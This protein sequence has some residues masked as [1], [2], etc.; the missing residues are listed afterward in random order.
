MK[1]IGI[2][3][4]ELSAVISGMGHRDMLGVVDAGFPITEKTQRIDLALDKGIPGFVETIKV[5]AKELEVEKIYLAK[6][7]QDI[8]PNIEKEI[9]NTFKDTPIEIVDHM[10]L[11]RYSQGARAIVRTGEFTPY[12][13]VILVSG[14]IF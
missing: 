1:K 14:V 9:I 13:N 6:E 11:E 4:Q 10:Q 8:N 3:N 2:L 12:A 5:I 7:T